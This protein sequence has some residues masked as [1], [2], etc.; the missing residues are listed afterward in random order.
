MTIFFNAL[1]A[2]IG[3]HASFTLGCAGQKGGLGLELG[4][5]ANEDVLI[6]VETRAGGH[7][8]ALPFYAGSDNQSAQYDHAAKSTKSKSRLGAFSLDVIR[9]DYQLGSD[10]WTAGDLTFTI[11]SPVESA[12]DPGRTSRSVQQAVYRPSVIAELT[13]DN[14]NGR[15]ARRAFFGYAGGGSTDSMRWFDGPGMTGIAKGSRTGIFCDDASVRSAQGFHAESILTEKHQQTH[16]EGLGGT[17]LLLLSVPAGQRKTFHFAI[18]FFRGGIVTTGMPTRYWYSRFFADLESVGRY[19]LSHFADIRRRALASNRLIASRKLNEAQRFQMIHAIRSYYGSTQLL[20]CRSKPVWVVN[21]GQYRMLNTFDLTVD[22]VFYEMT[23]NPWT[24]RNELDLFTARY[25][26]TDRVHFPGGRNEHSGGLSFTHDMGCCNHF[27]PPG[28]SSY[29]RFGLTGCFS[30]MTHEQLVNWILCAAIYFR[31]TGDRRWMT[32]NLPVL[33]K[34]LASMLNRDHPEDSKRNGVMGLDSDR[35]IDG[36]EITTYD[37]LDKSLGQAR[38]NMYIALKG[39]ASYLAME[40]IFME[41]ACPREA[42]R[43]ARQ[44]R[45]AADTMTSYLNADGFIPAILGEPCDARIIPAIEGL[46]FPWVLNQRTVLAERGPY[47]A[48]IKALKTHF[49]TVFQAGVCIYPDNGW[50]L[51]SS[52][53]NSW[54]SKIYLCQFVARKILGVKTPATGIAADEAHRAWLLK[55]ENLYFAWS[56]Q[57]SSGVAMGS[58]YYPRGVTSVLWLHE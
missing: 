29:E 5:P 18:C 46:V 7:F 48:L 20:D 44:A 47:G 33:K 52:A 39:W 17:G 8:E 58:K 36:A 41:L 56:D 21:E 1:H 31:G 19:S 51:S 13:I 30:H 15:R 26:Y 53:D 9:R 12:P 22:Q 38:N 28:Y 54:L 11:F 25:S 6:G 50:K 43:S 10:T 23:L 4:M 35:T 45:R 49:A 27:S 32:S 40:S 55:S 37:S 34:C 14:R 3:A 2:P 42:A 24:V 16:K 57:M